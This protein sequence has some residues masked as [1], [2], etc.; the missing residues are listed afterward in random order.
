MPLKAKFPGM[1]KSSWYPVVYPHSLFPE[2][3]VCND[4]SIKSLVD[5]TCPIC[6]YRENIGLI[7]DFKLYERKTKYKFAVHKCSQCVKE[8]LV[9]SE[10]QKPLEILIER[11]N[12]NKEDN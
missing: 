1:S 4:Y 3:K 5:V 2:I 7:F 12:D 10:P 6:G 9:R 8:M 11:L